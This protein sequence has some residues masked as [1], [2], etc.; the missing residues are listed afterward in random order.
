[1]CIFSMTH[2]HRRWMPAHADLSEGLVFLGASN[3]GPYLLER[4]LKYGALRL[5]VADDGVL[6]GLQGFRIRGP[7]DP[8]PRD[9]EGAPV[10]P[11]AQSGVF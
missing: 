7:Y 9:P 3:M 2:V 1:M 6:V 10:V 11:N 5:F 8:K 4:D